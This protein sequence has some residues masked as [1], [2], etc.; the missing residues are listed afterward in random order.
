MKKVLSLFKRDYEGT[1]QAYD[2]VVKGCE[3]VIAGEGV[4]TLKL[5]GTSCLVQDGVLYKRYDAKK[6]KTPP[7]GWLPCE[8]APNE[9]TGHWPG[10]LPVSDKPEDRWHREA[11]QNDRGHPYADGTYELLG[12][13]IQGNPYGYVEHFLAPHG[14]VRLH[15][16]PRDFEGL[17]KYFANHEIEGIVWWRDPS[18]SD[19]DKCK[20]KRKDFGLPWPPKKEQV[21]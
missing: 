2:Y 5:D 17:K 12:P 8:D 4:A 21:A 13:K 7:A 20:V 3:W 9:H 18:N 11:F 10:W 15:G 19:C 6:G 16:V 1:R 14:Q